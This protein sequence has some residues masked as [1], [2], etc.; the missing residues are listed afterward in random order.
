MRLYY[1]DTALEHPW[2]GTDWMFC[3]SKDLLSAEISTDTEQ[4][5]KFY[6]DK[7]GVKDLTA[8]LF[9]D[10]IVSKNINAI[11]KATSKPTTENVDKETALSAIAIAKKCNFDFVSYLNDNI[12]LVYKD[13]DFTKFNRLALLDN[14][15]EFIENDSVTFFYDETLSNFMSNSWNNL[16]KQ[17]R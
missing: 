9:Y 10:E 12:D 15:E 1:Y 8:Q 3:L 17:E 2:I 13:N 16:E 14:N 11:F 6:E 4:L 5:K 7:F